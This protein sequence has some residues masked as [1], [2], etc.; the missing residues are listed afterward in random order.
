MPFIKLAGVARRPACRGA[1][2]LLIIRTPPPLHTLLQTLTPTSQVDR[3]V[4]P[5]IILQAINECLA[6][7]P[8]P[9]I[10]SPAITCS[11]ESTALQIVAGFGM[12]IDVFTISD[13]RVRRH[14]VYH[15]GKPPLTGLLSYSPPHA[16]PRLVVPSIK[17]SVPL[18]PS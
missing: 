15:W 16:F 9:P 8:D 18:T 6:T 11:L 2:L 1:S 3:W 12:S 13:L 5:P 17:D 4:P 10:Q 7:T 14:C